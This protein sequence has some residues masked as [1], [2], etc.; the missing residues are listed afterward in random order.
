MN[1]HHL[2]NCFEIYEF[3]AVLHQRHAPSMIPRKLANKYHRQDFRDVPD[4]PLDVAEGS[5]KVIVATV[6]IVPA[7][8]VKPDSRRQKAE[9]VAHTTGRPSLSCP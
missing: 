7:C 3:D 5:R 6:Y 9:N 2:I 8:T 1:L 4:E